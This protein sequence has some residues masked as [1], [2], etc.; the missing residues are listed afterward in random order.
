MV[1]WVRERKERAT[2]GRLRIRP[3]TVSLLPLQHL[4][5]KES[6]TVM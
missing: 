1:N 2:T 3:G 6:C 5:D 4:S